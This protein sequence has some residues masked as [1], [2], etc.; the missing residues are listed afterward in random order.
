MNPDDATTIAKAVAAL[1]QGGVIAY[2]TEAVYGLG[3]D[4]F[5]AEAIT[6]ILQIKHR[7]FKQGFILVADNWE[8]IEPLVQPIEP[9]TLYSILETW[10]GPVTW[11]FPARPSVPDW[12]RG[13]HQGVAVRISDH[14]IVKELCQ[15]FGGPIVSTSANLHG[16]PAIRDARTVKIT[17]GNDIDV[18]V[19][20]KVG[21][22]K[23]PTAI[24]DAVTGDIIR[25]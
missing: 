9:R 2:P 16:Q 8:Q 4:P 20:G 18:I 11:I 7:S 23:K 19:D 13:E 6:K 10:P 5:N 3:C 14:P 12:I 24:K 22:L 17:F 25:E 1:Q 15:Q 21:G